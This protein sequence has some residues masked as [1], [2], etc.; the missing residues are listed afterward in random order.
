M[1]VVFIVVAGIVLIVGIFGIVLIVSSNATD[2]ELRQ[3]EGHI[4]TLADER[5]QLEAEIG[6]RSLR[7]KEIDKQI[8]TLN[9]ERLELGG[10]E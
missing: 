9:Q 5:H 10:G 6:E 7:L 4:E 3:I 1:R 8:E 2:R